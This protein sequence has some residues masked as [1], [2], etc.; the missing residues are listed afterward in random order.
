MAELITPAPPA[1]PDLLQREFL[2]ERTGLGAAHDVTTSTSGSEALALVRA[3]QRFDLILFDLMMPSVTGMDVYDALSRLVPDQAAR[4]V[5]L[6]GGA[7]TPR[8]EQ[9]LAEIGDR[10]LD[11]PFDVGQ[12]RA[13]VHAR[14]TAPAVA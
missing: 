8:A 5:F 9:F 6:T 14:L 11:K 4:M 1:A 12:L 7:F 2:T 13:A 10:L 3:G